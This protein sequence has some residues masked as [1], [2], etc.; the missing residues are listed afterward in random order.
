MGEIYS[1]PVIQPRLN[2]SDVMEKNTKQID[3]NFPIIYYNYIYL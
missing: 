3:T 1:I 2:E